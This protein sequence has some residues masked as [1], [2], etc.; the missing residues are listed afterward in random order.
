MFHR[1]IN[2]FVYVL[3]RAIVDW[4]VKTRVSEKIKA[5]CFLKM[6]R[7][8][9]FQINFPANYK[10]FFSIFF[11][12]Q[13]NIEDDTHALNGRKEAWKC[14]KSCARFIDELIFPLNFN[15]KELLLSVFL[16]ASLPRHFSPPPSSPFPHLI[17]LTTPAPPKLCPS[18]LLVFGPKHN[19]KMAATVKR[20][21]IRKRRFPQSSTK[22]AL[23]T[24]YHLQW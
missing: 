8:N 23:S 12:V 24:P 21:G 13:R 4:A 6:I 15:L 3:Y 5:V 10:Y 11:S 7:I 22:H 9:T 17:F 20:D 16:S 1:S 19:N 14:R 2:A 18:P